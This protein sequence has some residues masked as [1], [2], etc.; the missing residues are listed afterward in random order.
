VIADFVG[1]FNTSTIGR[2]QPVNGRIL[3]SEKR[4]VLAADG[5]KTTIPISRIF[6]VAVGIVPPELG[7]FFDSTVTIAFN[8]GDAGH[9]AAVAS[10]DDKIKRFSNV[11][12][13][14]LLNGTTVT[15][16]HPA[17]IGG[18]VTGTDFDQVTIQVE[19][20]AVRF[21]GPDRQF[22]IELSAITDF[23]IEEHEIGGRTG[24][25]LTVRHLKD[26]RSL[27][28]VMAV[29]DARRMGIL[30]RFLRL[31]YGDVVADV[32]EVEISEEEAELMVALYAG[33]EASSLPDVLGMDEGRVETLL[34]D[35]ERADLVETDRRSPDAAA[36][37]DAGGAQADADEAASADIAGRITFKGHIALSNEF[38]SVFS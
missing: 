27:E 18:R 13:K 36:T 37:A 21:T 33:G 3:L 26:G 10:D 1:K 9:V 7:E 6:D 34:A 2:A 38:E 19:P 20:D 32:D 17:I 35:L 16:Q 28:T 22:T 8:T 24:E 15:V 12:F 25:V 23:G 31:E 30:S 4:L 5:S 14:V 29:E 11:L